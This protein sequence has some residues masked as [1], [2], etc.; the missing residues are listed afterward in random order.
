M[1]LVMLAFDKHRRQLIM[2]SHICSD[3]SKTRE[4]FVPFCSSADIEVNVL[5]PLV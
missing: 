1:M 2:V 3:A 5:I 4:C